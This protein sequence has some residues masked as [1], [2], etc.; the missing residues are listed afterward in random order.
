[1]KTWLKDDWN[2]DQHIS[3]T[4]PIPIG[5]IDDKFLQEHLTIKGGIDQ[6]QRVN[7][8]IIDKEGV[9]EIMQG[10]HIT[11]VDLIE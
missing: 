6:G 8:K 4:Y 1:M 2:W 3:I 9:K 11:K 10:K 7:K 5:K